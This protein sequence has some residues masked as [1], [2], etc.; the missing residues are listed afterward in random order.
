MLIFDYKFI[1]HKSQGT[2]NSKIIK[3]TFNFHFVWNFYCHLL[4]WIFLIFL[5]IDVVNR[6]T[7]KKDRK[8]YF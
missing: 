7:F 8:F 4:N 2:N 5:Y 6:K 3:H 1:I